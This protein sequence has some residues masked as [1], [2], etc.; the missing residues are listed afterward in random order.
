MWS[1]PQTNNWRSYPCTAARN[2][3]QRWMSNQIHSNHL[4]LAKLRCPSRSLLLACLNPG[5][6]DRGLAR[7]NLGAPP[8]S[9][10]AALL[11]AA[12]TAQPRFRKESLNKN[13]AT[14]LAQPTSFQ[15]KFSCHAQG[16]PTTYPRR[17][18]WSKDFPIWNPAWSRTLFQPPRSRWKVALCCGPRTSTQLSNW[19]KKRTRTTILNLNRHF[20]VLSNRRHNRWTIS[21]S[22]ISSKNYS[23]LSKPPVSQAPLISQCHRKRCLLQFCIRSSTSKLQPRLFISKRW[24]KMRKERR[25]WTTSRTRH[26]TS[27]AKFSTKNIGKLTKCGSDQ[28][29]MQLNSKYKRT[30]TREAKL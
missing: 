28:L 3:P 24:S 6:D 11:N 2:R 9:L 22:L 14:S 20:H 17:R 15:K 13:G 12:I 4:S 7:S 23:A 21:A 8:G 29:P 30:V 1:M 5:T 16:R 25:V 18:V 19:R 27:W 10:E 26:L